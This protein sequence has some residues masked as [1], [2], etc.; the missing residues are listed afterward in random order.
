VNHV[1]SEQRAEIVASAKPSD[2]VLRDYYSVND[3]AEA[4]YAAFNRQ[5]R[6]AVQERGLDFE[7]A[8]ADWVAWWL[9]EDRWANRGTRRGQFVMCRFGDLGA[10]RL[11]NIYCGT[12][13]DNGRE[14]VESRMKKRRD[15]FAAHDA[16]HLIDD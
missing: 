5:W 10:Y 12:V 14:A 8:F 15:F 13:T 4:M 16:T 2:R 6:S 9:T 7:I 3:L 1:P 11:G